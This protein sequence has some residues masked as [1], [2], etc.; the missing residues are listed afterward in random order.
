MEKCDETLPYHSTQWN[1][2]YMFTYSFRLPESIYNGTFL[3]S[4]QVIVPQPG[5]WINGF[6]HSA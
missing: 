3:L 4:N 5:L 1:N 2:E 6:P